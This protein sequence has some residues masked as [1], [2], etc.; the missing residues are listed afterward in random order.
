VTSVLVGTEKDKVFKRTNEYFCHGYT[1]DGL[2]KFQNQWHLSIM[3][4]DVPKVL[5]DEWDEEIN[6]ATAK[7]GSIAVF[8]DANGTV[9]HSGVFT[10]V[11]TIKGN[12]GLTKINENQSTLNGKHGTLGMLKPTTLLQDTAYGK[13]K[14]FSK[15]KNEQACT[16][17][18]K[19]ELCKL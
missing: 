18:A 8:Y 1:F 15:K 2:N 5:E 19:H 3:G 17:C 4:F 13:Y 7:A 12:D 6:C 11:V 16:K 10:N 14:C 9:K